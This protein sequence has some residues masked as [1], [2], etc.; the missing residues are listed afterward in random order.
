M[1]FSLVLNSVNMHTLVLKTF[2]MIIPPKYIHKTPSIIIKKKRTLCGQA[3]GVNRVAELWR[4]AGS[5]LSHS[6]GGTSCPSEAFIFVTQTI[7]Q[8]AQKGHKA[9][10]LSH[11]L[12]IIF[13]FTNEEN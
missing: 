8:V 10:V 7:Y 4:C 6:T 12:N 5:I 1:K 9:V 2:T 13:S 3:C 11:N